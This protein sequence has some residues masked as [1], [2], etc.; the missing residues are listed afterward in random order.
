MLKKA[1]VWAAAGL[2]LIAAVPAVSSAKVH[3]T[4]HPVRSHVAKSHSAT[5]SVKST[6]KHKKLSASHRHHKKLSAKRHTARK[7]TARKLTA[8]KSTKKA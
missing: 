2:F 4:H 6:K 3:R 7:L 1:V 8:H 5:A